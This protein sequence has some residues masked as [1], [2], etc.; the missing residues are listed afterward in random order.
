MAA[1][2]L[3]T[4]K[5][6]SRAP[7]RELQKKVVLELHHQITS[8]VP[9]PRRILILHL[10]PV[11]FA[12]L[13]PYRGLNFH[14]TTLQST[15]IL[16]HVSCAGHGCRFPVMLTISTGRALITSFSIF[17]RAPENANLQR[18]VWDGDLPAEATHLPLIA[19]TLAQRN[20]VVRPRGLS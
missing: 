19:A 12:C 16:Q 14:Q 17:Q 5:P 3:L 15:G 11:I 7:Q 4:R 10:V 13:H 9:F 8:V 6:D 18:V 2:S 1:I 20:G